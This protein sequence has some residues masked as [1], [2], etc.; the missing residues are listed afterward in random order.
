MKRII[1]L[2][3]AVTVADVEKLNELLSELSFKT[4]VDVEHNAII[5]YGGND[6]VRMTLYYLKEAGYEVL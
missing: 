2:I 3:T 1:N 4:E 6:E 5:V